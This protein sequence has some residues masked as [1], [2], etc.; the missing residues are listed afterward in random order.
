MEGGIGSENLTS[1]TGAPEGFW[2]EMPIENGR[3]SVGLE[4]DAVTETV[5]GL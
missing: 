2:T 3:P 4:G 5:R 1:E